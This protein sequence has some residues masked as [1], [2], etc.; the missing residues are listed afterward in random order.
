M[1]TQQTADSGP[2]A[3]PL[4]VKTNKT[5]A[6]ADTVTAVREVI[7]RRRVGV[8]FALDI[9]RFDIYP[10]WKIQGRY[11]EIKIIKSQRFMR[12]QENNRPTTYF[13]PSAI[14]DPA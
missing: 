3:D 11:F 4:L 8:Q 2:A 14:D 6:L 9:S 13:Y 10:K 5:E 7:N 1:Q 12:D